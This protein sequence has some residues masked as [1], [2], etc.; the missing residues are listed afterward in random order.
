MHQL[1][2]TEY[3]TLTSFGRADFVRI[4]KYDEE[5]EDNIRQQRMRRLENRLLEHRGF[6]W[7]IEALTGGDLS[8]LDPRIFENMIQEGEDPAIEKRVLEDIAANIKSRLSSKGGRPALVGHNLFMDLIYLEQCFYGNSP[9]RVEDFVNLLHKKFPML[10][11]TKYIF[12]HD[13]GDM[14]PV[15]SLEV[16]AEAHKNIF[17][18]EICK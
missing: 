17:K 4:V 16:I 3:P 1:V 7:I 13:C 14:N 18:P 15:A 2:E 11:D 8:Q 9:D 12:T 10:I 5:R 6:R